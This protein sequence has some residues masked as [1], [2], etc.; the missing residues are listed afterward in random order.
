M[1][2]KRLY[3]LAILILSCS[4]PVWSGDQPQWGE[5][6]TRNMVSDETGL[7]A[8]F[9]PVTGE[10]V[11][12]QI[13]LGSQTYSTPV[14]S[15][16]RLLIGT[17]NDHPRNDQHK[18]DRGVLFCLDSESGELVWQLIV[19]KLSGDRYL[20][21]PKEGIVS[22]AT[23][24]G[25]H[26][27]IVSNR[28]EVM[29]LDIHGLSDGNDGPYQFEAKHMIPDG[30]QD[31]IELTATD[32]DILWLYDL[33]AQAGVYQHD[34]AHA[35]I[36]L[37]QDLLYLNTSN[38]VDNTHAVIRAP[39]APSLVVLDKDTGELVATDQEGIGPNIFHCTWS[40]PALARQRERELILF[41]GGNGICY[42]F[43]PADSHQRNAALEKVWWYDGDP[44][45]PK[46]NVHD[47]LRNRETSPSNIK[48]MP[49]YANGKLFLTLG[50]DIWWGKRKAWLQCVDI[51]GRG[52]ISA[53]HQKWSYALNKHVCTTPSV[54]QNM[55]FV[56]DCGHVVH[57]VN[58]ET[59]EPFWT[60][61]TD[62]D[63]W[64]SALVADGKLYVA[65]R[66]GSVYV[67]RA[68]ENKEL[69]HEIRLDGAI[70]ATPVAANGV[71]YI[72]TMETLYA[73]AKQQD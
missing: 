25:D 39:D 16:G 24:D 8:S 18:G 61:E 43:N 69:L 14:I 45:A 11:K 48:S 29:C 23:V 26:V 20:D 68:S 9:N 2:P 50:G 41:A 3:V 47:Y 10:N 49:V 63:I 51:D 15:Q 46:T 65:T 33:R 53:S 12:W 17:N 55:V 52:D 57:C 58:A 1:Q 19:P 72:A 67:F 42:A 28:G 54:Y 30:E 6:Y 35:S 31:I 4:G 13:P 32:A 40:S 56:G 66:R 64:A 27:Y 37:V 60:H 44:F 34:A 5:R 70:N 36:L 62:G 71:L 73:F 7:P 22:P 21:W 38:G 59:G